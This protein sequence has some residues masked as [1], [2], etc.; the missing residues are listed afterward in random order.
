MLVKGLGAVDLI[1]GAIL[2]LSGL[3]NIPKG[4][5][6]FFGI[7]LIAKSFLGM[8][9]DFAGW[10]DISSGI[11]L[12]ISSFANVPVLLGVIFGVLVIQKGVVSFL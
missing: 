12:I 6:I 7:V 1:A 10:I 9:K 3:I 2:V 11:I 8:L 5:L 4:M